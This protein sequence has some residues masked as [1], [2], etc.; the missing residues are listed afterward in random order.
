MNSYTYWPSHEPLCSKS[1]PVETELEYLFALEILLQTGD[2][3]CTA[4]FLLLLWGHVTPFPIPLEY[5]YLWLYGQPNFKVFGRLAS[6][7][8]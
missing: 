6:C 2:K 8:K 3:D 7:P 4:I 5:Y 1:C